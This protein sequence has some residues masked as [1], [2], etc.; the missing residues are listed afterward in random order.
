MCIH[1]QNVT[2]VYTKCNICIQWCVST[3]ICLYKFGIL[4]MHTKILYFHKPV[5][6]KLLLSL[7]R[8]SVHTETK[9]LCKI[10]LKCMS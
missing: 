9:V 3:Y 2:F 8:L 10:Y 7:L 6:L 4:V 5:S 1:I